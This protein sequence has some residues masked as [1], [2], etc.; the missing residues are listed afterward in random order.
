[1][2]RILVISP[3]ATHPQNAGNSARIYSFLSH[4]KKKGHQIHL[5]LVA[6]SKYKGDIKAMEACWNGFYYYPHERTTL[7][8]IK[9]LFLFLYERIFPQKIIPMGI[10]DWYGIGMDGIIQDLHQSLTF[11]CVL[12]QYAY[13]SRAFNNFDNGVRK[14]IDT[15]DVFGGRYK[16]FIQNKQ[17]PTFFYTTEEE[18]IIGLK[19]AD[20]II[21]IQNKEQQYFQKALDK[22]VVTIGHLMDQPA[23]P[24]KEKTSNEKKLLYVGSANTVNTFALKWFLSEVFPKIKQ[25]IPDINLYIVGTICNVFQ[26][27]PG[28]CH[29]LG[30]VEDLTALYRT[31]DIVI[32]PIKFG[33]GLKIKS[34]EALAYG[35]PLVTTSVGC[36]GIEDG[37]NNAFLLA[38]SP[39]EFAQSIIKILKD[40][41]FY[42][43]L[44]KCAYQYYENYQKEN[45][46]ILSQ[47]FK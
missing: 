8:Y 19:R 10:D 40:D 28:R 22:N 12:V 46:K 1:M 42:K 4:L 26:D 17:R 6:R 45:I 9:A 13:F 27:L 21:A 18:E 7:Y 36:E 23:P 11:D 15:H 25:E 43:K 33:S 2:S 16:K 32:N 39:T 3:V 20:T 37:I 44:S 31:T 47:I 14:I 29:S 5:L 34:I 30:K 38:E 41:N 24:N 35:L